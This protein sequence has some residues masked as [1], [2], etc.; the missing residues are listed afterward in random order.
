MFP[1]NGGAVIFSRNGLN[2]VL[3]YNPLHAF[4]TGAS[5]WESWDEKRKTGSETNF[6][7]V[8]RSV[9]QLHQL[10]ISLAWSLS[11]IFIL[12]GNVEHFSSGR[13]LCKN[14]LHEAS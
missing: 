4:D 5:F 10:H 2:G 8:L 3:P 13:V 11:Q 6:T 12:R 14:H 9:C 7:A 1:P